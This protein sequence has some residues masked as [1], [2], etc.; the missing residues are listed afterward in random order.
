MR[1]YQCEIDNRY[2]TFTRKTD[3]LPYTGPH[4]IIPMAYQGRFDVSIDIPENIVSLCSNCH[5]EIHYGADARKLLT[6]LY[7]QRKDQLM[8]AGINI[9]LDELLACYGVK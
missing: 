4:H 9:T 1:C 5:N 8:T 6:A 7:E 2:P 3:G